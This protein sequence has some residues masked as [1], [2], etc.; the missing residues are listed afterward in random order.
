VFEA[1]RFTCLKARLS[2]LASSSSSR[3]KRI[4]VPL[5]YQE[6]SIA[7]GFQ[8]YSSP[9]SLSQIKLKKKFGYFVGN[10]SCL[11][12]FLISKSDYLRLHA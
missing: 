7:Q 4:I 5:S 8:G 10:A 2:L 6:D 12:S 11:D 3:F 9:F 1:H